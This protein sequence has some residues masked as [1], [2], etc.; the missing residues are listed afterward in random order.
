MSRGTSLP[1]YAEGGGCGGI[2]D[3]IDLID[4]ILGRSGHLWR[5]H[6]GKLSSCALPFCSLS[7]IIACRFPSR[8]QSQELRRHPPFRQVLA[9][10]ALH[11]NK[12]LLALLHLTENFCLACTCSALEV[13]ENTSLL[14]TGPVRAG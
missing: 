14:C 6:S 12:F 8:T 9:D 13:P 10:R 7:K 4:L 3:L 5:A 2:V 11:D 1:Q